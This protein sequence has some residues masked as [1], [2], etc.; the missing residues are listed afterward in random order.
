MSPPT[1]DAIVDRTI[2]YGRGGAGNLRK[3][4]I[5]AAGTFESLDPTPAFG[6]PSWSIH[7]C[8]LVCVLILGAYRLH[9]M[10]KAIHERRRQQ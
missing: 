2:S 10:A 1:S 6:V 9:I 7:S 8:R 4:S 3:K 5:D